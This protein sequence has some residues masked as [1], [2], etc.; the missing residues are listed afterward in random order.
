MQSTTV[1]PQL[2]VII[3]CRDA[4][5][6]LGVQ[7]AAL[8]RQESPVPWEVLICDNGST[9]RTVALAETWADRLPLRVVDASGIAGAGPARNAGVQE[10]RGQW[11]AFCD[12][13]DEVGEG[14]LV[15]VCTALAEHPFVAGRFEGTR[16]N[17]ARTLRSRQLDQQSDLQR[18]SPAVGL[19]HAGAGNLAMHRSVFLEVGGFDPAVRYLQDTDLCWRVQLAGYP[20][21]FVPEMEVHVRL[22][23]TL[24]TMYR[25]GRNYG[26]SQASLERR[27]AG[28]AER[29]RATSVPSATSVRGG[30]AV[31][32]DVVAAVG[33]QR[34]A[35][36][37]SDEGSG[38]L[39]TGS[40]MLAAGFRLARFF[41]SH[42]SSLGAQ[43]WQLG[44]HVGHRS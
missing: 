38:L 36:A 39:T 29:L 31:A 9:D 21:V 2:S 27:Y 44:W 6:V 32:D 8:A 41:V 24:R 42:R 3:A 7:L 4:Q 12:A 17:S 18:S 13:D 37:A 40:H 43:V 28:A 5:D 10:A 35:G 20:L 33:T 23:S 14:W 15:A 34:T 1:A 26:A 19:P 30:T 11:L 22:R 25:Q 16:L